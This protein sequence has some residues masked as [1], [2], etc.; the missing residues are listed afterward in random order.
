MTS[1]E[2]KLIREHLDSIKG[3]IKH[4]EIDVECKLVP[5]AS[6]L[7]FAKHHAESALSLLDRMEAE[8]EC[9]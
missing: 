4:W 5:T 9:A 6:S 8:K 3:W 2:A 1:T 7:M